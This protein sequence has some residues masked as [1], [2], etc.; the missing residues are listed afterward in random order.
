MP[1]V[2]VQQSPTAANH[3]PKRKRKRPSRRWPTERDFTVRSA[4]NEDGPAIAA[5][6]HADGPD[7][8]HLDWS[9]IGT[10]WIV[11]D[12]DGV[13]VGVVQVCQGKP[14]GR[15]EML[16]LDTTRSKTLRAKALK[17]LLLTG[18]KVLAYFGSQEV[19]FLAP[20]SNDDYR[21]IVERYGSRRML[22]GVIYAR[23]LNELAE[24]YRQIAEELNRG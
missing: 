16:A 2:A 15:L 10:G 12:R 14:V 8:R 19:Q 21:K 20:A 23:P 7:F 3:S 6:L 22:E 5:L 13:L 18:C 17:A 4:K 1:E 24:R 11:A 9:D